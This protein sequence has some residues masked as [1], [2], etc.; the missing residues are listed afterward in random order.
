MELAPP[1]LD[2]LIAELV[3]SLV[4]AAGRALDRRER[5]SL[6]RQLV[7]GAPQVGI[8]LAGEGRATC[9]VGQLGRA[10][11]LVAPLTGRPCAY[12]QLELQVRDGWTWK[13][14]GRLDPGPTL[15]QL[16]DD[17]GVARV[18]TA[19]ALIVLERS[20]ARSRTASELDPRER[21][22]WLDELDVDAA[23]LADVPHRFTERVLAPADRLVVVGLGVREPDRD[24]LTRERAF[25]DRPPSALRL[26]STARHRL[27]IT[28][29]VG[30]VPGHRRR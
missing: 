30:E 29:A 7:T 23:R 8:A 10:A 4:A 25:R 2:T 14:A 28:D 26:S 24:D 22:R 9:V 11:P 21:A 17:S 27:F 15:L 5:R 12:W 3:A 16:R 19:G 20:H 18:E 1:V 13:G 6:I